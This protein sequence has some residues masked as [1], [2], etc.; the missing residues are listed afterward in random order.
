[1]VVAAWHG[2][3]WYLID[4]VGIARSTTFFSFLSMKASPNPRATTNMSNTIWKLVV[5]QYGSMDVCVFLFD[6][7]PFRFAG[8]A[9]ATV[10]PFKS[11]IIY[12]VRLD[13]YEMM[14]E[15]ME[16]GMDNAGK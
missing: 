15:C 13:R 16:K 9:R 11:Y 2:M 8:T 14:D 1:V 5:M 10:A 12:N 6:C 3:E 7:L 4:D